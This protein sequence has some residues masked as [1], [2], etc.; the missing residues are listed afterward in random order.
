MFSPPYLPN[1]VSPFHGEPLQPETIGHGSA[2]IPWS[3]R[4]MMQ[5]RAVLGTSS[6]PFCDLVVV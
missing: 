2:S 1:P 4:F 5:S 3:I 6:Q